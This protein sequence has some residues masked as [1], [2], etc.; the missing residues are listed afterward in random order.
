MMVVDGHACLL[1]CLCLE[2]KHF[3]HLQRMARSTE[4]SVLVHTGHFLFV[5][6][7]FGIVS[8]LSLTNLFFYRM[9]QWDM[10]SSCKPMMV[11]SNH[12]VKSNC[13]RTVRTFIFQSVEGAGGGGG[14][15]FASSNRTTGGVGHA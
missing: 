4:E 8:F 7:V 13:S 12:V 1:K 3:P 14:P 15:P 6:G 5:F 9:R 2:Q 10:Q 11:R